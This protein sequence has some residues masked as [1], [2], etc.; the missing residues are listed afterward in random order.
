MEKTKMKNKIYPFYFVIGALLIYLVFLVLPGVVGMAYSFTDWSS[1][2]TK[3]DF[4]G[5]DNFKEIFFGQDHY[6]AYMSNTILFTIVSTT[7]KLIFSII[8]AL[9]LNEGIKLKNFHRAIIF[10]PAILSML[11]TGLIFKSILDPATGILDQALRNIGLGFLA[12]QWL[13]DPKFA[14]GSI[15]G[16]DTWKGV[17][18]VMTIILAGLQSISPEYYEAANI[19][20]ASYMKKLRYVT[21]PLLRPAI[22]VTVVLGIFY[23]LKVFDIVYVMTN[24]GPGYATTV[25]NTS[26]YDLFGLGNWGLGTALNTLLF[27]FM[28]VVGVFTVRL[29]NQNEGEKNET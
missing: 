23:G 19:D 16:V 7:V 1:Y 18:Y 22:T 28:I 5:L 3:L 29:L 25:L 24:G 9:I 10:M 13:V 12:Q 17:G 11:I 20:G 27:V 15:I 8:F 6:L 2:G 14:F 26:I 21:F 4:V